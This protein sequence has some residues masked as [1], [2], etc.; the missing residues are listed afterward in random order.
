MKGV[1]PQKV[2]I[3]N[4][5]GGFAIPSAEQNNLIPDSSVTLADLECRFVAIRQKLSGTTL[6]GKY[7]DKSNI[8]QLTRISQIFAYQEPCEEPGLNL[9]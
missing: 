3:Q 5:I 2:G 4:E 8:E 9:G 1:S 6:N 7:Q